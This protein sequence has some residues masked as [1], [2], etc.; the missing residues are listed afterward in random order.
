MGQGLPLCQ[1]SCW[2][3]NVLSFALKLHFFPSLAKV[4]GGQL[5]QTFVCHNRCFTMN[6]LSDFRP[7][8]ILRQDVAEESNGLFVTIL[9]ALF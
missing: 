4:A 2:S 8:E 7:F 1:V 6:K 5:V 9:A 3:H